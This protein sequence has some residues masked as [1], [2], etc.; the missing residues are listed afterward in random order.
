MPHLVYLPDDEPGPFHINFG[1]AVRLAKSR[2]HM[3]WPQ[4]KLLDDEDL[5]EN[6]RSHDGV[7][8]IPAD[9]LDALLGSDVDEAADAIAEGEVDDVLGAVLFAEREHYGPRPD[10]I[11][12]VAER[13]DKLAV[14]D[15]QDEDHSDLSPDDVVVG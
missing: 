2:S 5:G 12:A 6:V 3:R 1:G 7:E 15:A 9:R 10:V 4:Y 11:G 8:H 13:S 14:Q